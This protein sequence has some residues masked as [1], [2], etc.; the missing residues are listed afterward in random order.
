MEPKKVQPGT[1]LRGH[2]YAKHQCVRVR[3]FVLTG[4][5][6]CVMTSEVGWGVIV[7]VSEV[8]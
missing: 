2:R 5:C 6:V 7:Y 1:R 4:A 8:Y 3:I